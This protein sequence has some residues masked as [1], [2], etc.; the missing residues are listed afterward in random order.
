MAV[1]VIGAQSS[2][3]TIKRCFLYSVVRG[4]STWSVFVCCSQSSHR[5]RR[6][7]VRLKDRYFSER[8]SPKKF[9]KFG[10]SGKLYQDT[11]AF[12][13]DLWN[14]SEEKLYLVMNIEFH[15]CIFVWGTN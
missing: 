9:R 1:I 12:C 6:G 5:S 3:N 4:M 8:F 2:E 13:H 14:P 10:I 11:E 7:S 15:I